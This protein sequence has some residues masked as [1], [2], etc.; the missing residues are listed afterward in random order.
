[1]GLSKEERKKGKAT[2]IYNPRSGPVMLSQQLE[3]FIE[4]WASTGWR[5]TKK[6]TQ[7]SGEAVELASAAATEGHT[8]IFAAGGDGTIS[9]VA[10]GMYGTSSILVPVPCGMGNT[11]AKEIGL[12]TP[13][14]TRRSNLLAL[15]K[16][17]LMGTVRSLDLGVCNN[18]TIW[19]TSLGAGIDSFVVDKI[20]P[21]TPASR[22]TRRLTK[23]NYIVSCLS[24]ARQFK[25]IVATVRVD[26]QIYSGEFLLVTVNNTRYYASSILYNPGAILDDGKVE[27]WMF[28]GSSRSDIL[29]HATKIV[30][31]VHY[32]D[33]EDI[34]MCK[35]SR[36][37]VETEEVFPFQRDGDPIG[38]TPFE[39]SVHPT[40]LKVLVPTQTKRQLPVL[41]KGIPFQEY[42]RI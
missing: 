14:Q 25:G 15:A 35:G 16:Q 9:E 20:E 42:T 28:R 26:D 13:R 2:L 31:G 22:L 4:I 8:L 10:Q 40:A 24:N 1:M 3:D 30:A 17:L 29:R 23:L 38:N 11:F 34:I 5:I 37:R 39:T 27:I 7:R 36:V 33:G 21:R 19:L 32:P 41:A 6:I 12:V 18:G